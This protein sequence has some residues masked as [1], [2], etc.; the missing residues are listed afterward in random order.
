MLSANHLIESDQSPRTTIIAEKDLMTSTLS[1]MNESNMVS[2]MVASKG[3]MIVPSK[4]SQKQDGTST[5]VG[6]P[7]PA[8]SSDNFKSSSNTVLKDERKTDSDKT[9]TNKEDYPSIPAQEYQGTLQNFTVNLTPQP[10][11]YQYIGYGQ[12]QQMT[13]EPPS[14]STHHPAVDGYAGGSFFQQSQTVPF[15]G[16][17]PPNS[18]ALAPNSQSLSVNN[19]PMSPPRGMMP[20]ISSTTG[21][22]FP[23]ASPLFPR[24]VV[25]GHDGST[26]PRA[27]PPS[28]NVSY[29]MTPG[30]GSSAGY[31]PYPVAGAS[32]RTNEDGTWGGTSVDR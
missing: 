19:V 16:R 4:E 13:P 10:S 25:S 3:E 22:S 5:A 7:N 23:P 20:I 15:G 27:A 26:Q 14:S 2:D 29:M 6:N 1:V 12:Q 31:P 8:P 9:S 30:S 18:F 17:P 11:T 21:G 28:P 24:A 32:G